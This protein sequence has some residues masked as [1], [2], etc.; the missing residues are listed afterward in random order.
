M[1]GEMA[2]KVYV[3]PICGEVIIFLGLELCPNCLNEIIPL[4][5]PQEER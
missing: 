5:T 2:V 4:A 1:D 3:C